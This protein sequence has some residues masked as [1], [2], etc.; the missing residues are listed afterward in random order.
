MKTILLLDQQNWL[1]GA[2][3]VL[4]SMLSVL[5]REEYAVVVAL[6]EGGT[7][8]AELDAAGAEAI[9]LRIGSYRSGRKSALE[10][11]LWIWRSVM[12][13]LRLARFIQRRNVALVYINGPRCL[14]AGVLAARLTGRP[15]IF[16]LHLI[17]R[18]MPDGLLAA[19]L[20]RHMAR[21]VACSR[22]AA[23]SLIEVDPQLSHKTQVIYGPALASKVGEVTARQQLAPPL[24]SG[25]KVEMRVGMVARITRSK[26]Q[27][28][29]LHAMSRL[30]SDVKERIGLVFLGCPEPGSAADAQYQDELRHLAQTYQLDQ[31]VVWAGFQENPVPWYRSLDVLA[32]PSPAEPMGLVLLE[33]LQQ[34][35]PV[36][37]T[38][39]GGIPEIVE[40][41]VNALLVPPSDQG[42]L[43]QALLLMLQDRELRRRL[44][45]GA[46]RGPGKRFSLETF[47]RNITGV[48]REL[49]SAPAAMPGSS[50]QSPEALKP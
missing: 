10:S 46:Q 44:Q 45:A 28:L 49:S 31:R 18:R 43:A 37:A 19:R 22:A 17:L 47:G 30:P 50:P 40:D 21:I 4:Q 12:C 7:F 14:P 42:A 34:G 41:G 38:R 26:G 3:R 8:R 32:H 27:H 9:P 1:G 24:F 35:V 23:A 39:G 5:P 13:G 16:H 48:I 20:A 6:P 15:A 2:Q 33:A 11:M 29:L 25:T 36:L